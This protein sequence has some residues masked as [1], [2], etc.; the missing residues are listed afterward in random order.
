MKLLPNKI[1]ITIVLSVP[2]CDGPNKDGP[3]YGGLISPNGSV[4]GR[5]I[6]GGN[7]VPWA[8]ARSRS[9]GDG[10]LFGRSDAPVG[11]ARAN[12]SEEDDLLPAGGVERLDGFAPAVLILVVEV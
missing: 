3:G 7:N 2:K 6:P 8:P 1:I 11:G 10:L 12:T 4:G 9:A 5:G